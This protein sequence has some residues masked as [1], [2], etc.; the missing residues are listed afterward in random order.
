MLKFV[1][2]LSE[3]AKINM[4]SNLTYVTAAWG[5]FII[6]VL[7]IFIFYYIWI[8]VYGGH[9]LLNGI[10]K[11]QMITYIILSRILFTQITWGFIYIMGEMIYTGEISMELLR[12]M[13][14]QLSM[15]VGRIGDLLAFGFM[16]GLPALIIGGI[17][18]GLYFPHNHL[19]YLYV[20]LSL[21][22]ALTIS[23]LVEFIM[24]L[25]AFYTTNSWGLQTLYEAL[26]SFFSGALVPLTFF[27][28]WIR[29]IIQILPFKDMM[30]T[31]I[32]IYL[33]L[34]KGQGIFTSLLYQLCWVIGLFFISRLFFMLSIK[35]VIVQGG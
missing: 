19:I 30:Y 5:A 23:F 20:L 2:K 15:Y 11:G 16:T 14:F 1:S 3:V 6:T 12:P 17:F 29:S 22:M 10:T 33:E 25:F 13:D 7:Q 8:A 31:P 24:A 18:L 21:F 26:I 35:K 9:S 27:P 28:D 34:I 4:K 32:A